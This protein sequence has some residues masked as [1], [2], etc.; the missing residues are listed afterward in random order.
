MTDRGVELHML[1]PRDP[2]F[3]ETQIDHKPEDFIS[4]A[5]GRAR[6]ELALI[7]LA[8]QGNCGKAESNRNL[9][10]QGALDPW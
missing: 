9:S 1:S 7:P 5:I 10:Q 3:A 8:L 2:V 6:I 4:L